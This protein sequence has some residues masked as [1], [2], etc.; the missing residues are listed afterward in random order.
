MKTAL[1]VGSRG[2]DGRLLEKHLTTQGCRVI[3]IGRGDADIRDF[4]QV[5]ALVAKNQPDETYFLAA[6]CALTLAWL[7]SRHGSRRYLAGWCS[8][9]TL[10]LLA[11]AA[12]EQRASAVPASRG[13]LMMT[14]AT[15]YAQL[16]IA[17][18]NRRL[19][20]PL[21]RNTSPPLSS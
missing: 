16:A 14:P 8:A 9:R 15:L 13:M 11:P 5:S 12:L 3:G 2:Q 21:P 18:N 20:P 6:A 4:E 10:H 17:A 7:A 19:P 1:I